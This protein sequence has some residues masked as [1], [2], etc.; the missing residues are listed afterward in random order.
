MVF[1]A[2][3]AAGRAGGKVR[4]SEPPHIAR[5]NSSSAA[6]HVSSTWR[7]SRE[8]QSQ[9]EA[10]NAIE[11]ALHRL[12]PTIAEDV[13]PLRQQLR[14]YS[15]VVWSNWLNRVVLVLMSI[16]SPPALSALRRITAIAM[17]G[18][19]TFTLHPKFF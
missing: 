8:A 19:R 2:T 12:G 10:R 16:I 15:P 17:P 14:E 7:M 18:A 3:T 11:V 1:A 4:M 6:G 5:R 9:H 13:Y